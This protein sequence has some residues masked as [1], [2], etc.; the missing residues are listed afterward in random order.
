MD[1]ALRIL[2]VAIALVATSAHAE[3]FTGNRLY[4][5][6]R[7][8]DPMRLA[9]ARGYLMGVFDAHQGSQ[10]CASERVSLQQVWDLSLRM[11]EA[12]ADI[13]HEP[14]DV[15]LIAVFSTAWPCAA[16]P[17]PNRGGGA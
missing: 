11:L 9:T 12:V 8:T 4:A 3:F 7:S 10:H 16:R 5:D 14:A 2:A 15:I 6:M 1:K 17:T 13:R